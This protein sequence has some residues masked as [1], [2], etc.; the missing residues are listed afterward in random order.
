MTRTRST[1]CRRG[2][3]L[4]DLLTALA[5][6]GLMIGLLLPAVQAARGA[7]QRAS[8]ASNLR[9][10][11]QAMILHHDAMGVFPSNGGW[12]GKQTIPSK[13]GPPVTITTTTSGA[14]TEWGVGDPELSPREQT[15]SWA[16]TILPYIEQRPVY[17]GR[18]WGTA[19]KLYSCP[20][21]R[22]PVSLPAEDDADGQYQ[23][24]GWDWGRID[25]AANWRV[26]Q[27]RPTCLDLAAF[28]DGSSNTIL[29][30]EKAMNPSTYHSGSWYFDEPYFSGGSGGT[31]RGGA[32]L[33]PD[34]GG[35]FALGQW[36]S[37]H[38]EGT[39]FVLADGS[40]RLTRYN[41]ATSVL[42]AMLT[43]SGG[44]IRPGF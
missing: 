1:R 30:G 10:V 14:K 17:D 38:V 19:I 27:N 7:A 15:G 5:I 43:P 8:C 18:S 24:G 4:I 31:A 34:T 25:Y 36:G 11:A 12:D 20:S 16:F 9:Q 33:V 42:E 22:E 37:S 39:H 29:A 2:L 13:A 40:V 21:R 3:S 23:G 35:R 28:T 44:E 6:V 26:V 32:Y 41:T